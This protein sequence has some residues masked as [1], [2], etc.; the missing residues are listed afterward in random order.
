M[1]RGATLGANCTIVCGTTIGQYAFVGA[2]SVINKDVPPFAL[3]VGVPGR[4]VG[5]M[6]RYGEQLDLPLTG[7]GDAVCPHT[8]DRYELRD[9]VCRL[10]TRGPG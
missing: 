5:W 8:R 9:G 3:V 7:N 2:G 4:Q 6:S 10:V 1:Q